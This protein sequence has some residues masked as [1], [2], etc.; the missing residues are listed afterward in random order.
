[1]TL[2]LPDT[3]GK[4]TI[5]NLRLH[6]YWPSMSKDVE[7]FIRECAS[8]AKMKGDVLPKPLW[9]NYP[10][11]QVPWRLPPLIYVVHIRSLGR[12]TNTFTDYFT[13]YPEA[14]PI[15][16]QEAGTVAKALVTQVFAR[17]GCPK[18]LSSDRG[19]NFVSSLSRDVQVTSNKAN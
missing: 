14:I 8:C 15:P 6:Y 13:R 16:N 12:E 2:S 4:R 3:K 19:T 5:S 18:V 17:H 1:M 9:V 10:K 11:R 7:K